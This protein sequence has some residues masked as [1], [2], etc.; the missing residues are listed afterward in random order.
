MRQVH[1]E[2]E[3]WFPEEWAHG[4][5]TGPDGKKRKEAVKAAL[6]ALEV[7]VLDAMR[8][9]L[10]T[11]GLQGD[12]LVDAGLLVR[13]AQTGTTP[14]KQVVPALEA[15]VLSTTGAVVRLR[16]RKLDGAAAHDWASAQIAPQ[17][18]DSGH[19]THEPSEKRETGDFCF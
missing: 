15:A 13:T 12:A 11:F 18:P 19:Y 1:S 10:P 2:V 14:L 3:R 17:R 8:E 9:A 5:K 7:D 16:A 6:V 4:R